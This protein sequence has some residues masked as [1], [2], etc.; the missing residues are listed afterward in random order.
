MPHF[1]FHLLGPHGHQQDDEGLELA[2]VEAAYLEAFKAVPG[3]GSDLAATARNP[4]RYGFEIT[5]AHGTILMVLPFAE[6]LDRGRKRS[7]RPTG[8][9]LRKGRAEMGRTA[10][11]II[12]LRDAHA[13]LNVTLSETQRLLDIGRASR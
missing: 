12:E 6:V 2:D 3:M 7:R 5:D 13:K 9:R 8:L 4:I 11:L 10:G 1:Y